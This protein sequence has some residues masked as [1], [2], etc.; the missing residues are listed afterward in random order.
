MDV[1]AYDPFLKPEDIKVDYVKL[2]DFDEIVKNSD[3]VTLHMPLTPDTKDLFASKRIRK[4][5]RRRLHY[6]RCTWWNC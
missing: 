3:I 2:V 1:L 6:K 5:E 4:D